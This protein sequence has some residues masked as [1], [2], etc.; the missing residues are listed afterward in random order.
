MSKPTKNA[1]CT[2]DQKGFYSPLVPFAVLHKNEIRMPLSSQS[3]SAHKKANRI[4]LRRAQWKRQ[5]QTFQSFFIRPFCGFFSCFLCCC[6]VFPILFHL[7]TKLSHLTKRISK[8]LHQHIP[9]VIFSLSSYLQQIIHRTRHSD[10]LLL[11]YEK[12]FLA[13]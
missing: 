11:G 3:F 1:L 10:T 4:P 7:F 8:C 5:S 6:I 2:K 13:E 12:V 9:F